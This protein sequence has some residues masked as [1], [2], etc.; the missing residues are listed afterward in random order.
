M[1]RAHQWK[2][3]VWFVQTHHSIFVFTYEINRND[4]Q[5]FDLFILLLSELLCDSLFSAADSR[6]LFR[7]NETQ[8]TERKLDNLFTIFDSYRFLASFC[9]HLKECNHS[10]DRW[11]KNYFPGNLKFPHPLFSLR[12]DGVPRPL[13]WGWGGSFAEKQRVPD[14][15]VCVIST[16]SPVT[17]RQKILHPEPVVCVW[18]TLW[19][20]TVSYLFRSMCAKLTFWLTPAS[21]LSS[22]CSW[23]P[24]GVGSLSSCPALDS[25]NFGPAGKESKAAFKAQVQSFAHAA[26]PQPDICFLFSLPF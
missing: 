5:K 6:I 21:P 20:R 8:S 23:N 4:T 13:F 14:F 26:Q 15:E 3:L 7:I 12:A 24:H 16:L 18:C 22:P 17:L 2:F 9:P 1:T 10:V 25:P 19:T 11:K